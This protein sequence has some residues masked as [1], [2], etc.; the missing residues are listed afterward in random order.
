MDDAY[1]IASDC[2]R[3]QLPTFYPDASHYL[4]HQPQSFDEHYSQG[5]G[6]MREMQHAGSTPPEVLRGMEQVAPLSNQQITRVTTMTT[7]PHSMTERTTVPV[8][9]K[10]LST[11][12]LGAQTSDNVDDPNNHWRKF[13]IVLGVILA[14]GLIILMAQKMAQ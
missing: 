2:E 13:L 10:S 4:Y 7:S 3:V 6:Q 5:L 9:S 14:L 12:T 11:D 8:S 1:A